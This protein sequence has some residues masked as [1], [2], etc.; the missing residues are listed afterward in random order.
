MQD[1]IDISIPGDGWIDF[2]SRNFP[3]NFNCGNICHYLVESIKKVCG[4]DDY[5]D[6]EYGDKDQSV[7]E[8]TSK[9]LKKGTWLLKSRFVLQP[10]DNVNEND[11]YY[12]LR[13]H[14]HHSV[15]NLHP[16][17]TEV[18]VSIMS[19]FIKRARCDCKA[20]LVG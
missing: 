3:Q 4:H 6:E 19:G 5:D 18:C 10:Q 16:L 7:G 15:K 17:F 2:P 12:I 20:G 1:F 8:V 9:S 11:Q 13:G 14:V